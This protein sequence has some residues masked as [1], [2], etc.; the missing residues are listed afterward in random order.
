MKNGRNTAGKFTTGNSGRPRGSRNKATLA[1]ESLLKGQAQAVTQAAVGRI[2]HRCGDLENALKNHRKSIELG[3][4]YS[5]WVK[6]G[7]ANILAEFGKHEEAIEFIME[8]VDSD[9]VNPGGHKGL[10]TVLIY[11]LIKTNRLREAEKRFSEFAA[12]GNPITAGQVNR[13]VSGGNKK[14]NFWDELIAALRQ[15]GL[16][17]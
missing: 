5:S 4:H 16:S 17:D 7:Y 15:V 3:P 14:S 8:Y 1:I 2:Q 9:F 11:S 6:R 10:S 13:I 12:S